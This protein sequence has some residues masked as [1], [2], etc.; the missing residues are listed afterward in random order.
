MNDI[1]GKSGPPI[2]FIAIV[3]LC[4]ASATVG[5]AQSIPMLVSGSVT[6][7]VIAL[8]VATLHARFGDV[9]WRP[10]FWGFA[11]AGW[12]YA[13]VSY[14]PLANSLRGSLVTDVLIDHL[15]PQ[16]PKDPQA[17][18]V[19][20]QVDRVQWHLAG[21]VMFAMVAGLAGGLFARRIGV[22]VQ[23]EIPSGSSS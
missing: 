16:A 18:N 2:G 12:A 8:I 19:W 5:I 13:I 4:I 9:R 14:G 23:D 10:F 3:V 15:M 11:L 6:L 7:L 17:A 1:R 22:R 21:H 20:Q